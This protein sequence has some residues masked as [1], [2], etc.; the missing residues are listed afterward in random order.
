MDPLAGLLPG[1][2]SQVDPAAVGAAGDAGYAVGTGT[3][4]HGIV[5]EVTGGGGVV[6][7]F[8]D[9]VL[10]LWA[11]INKPIST[12]MSPYSIFVGVGVLLI[13]I[14]AWNFILYHVR[15]AAESI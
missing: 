3:G 10:S 2:T 4:Q 6:G 1:T 8:K 5:P 9:T 15:I 12:P 11:W 7:L 14:L 13:V